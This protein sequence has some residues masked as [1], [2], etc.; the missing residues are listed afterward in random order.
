MVYKELYHGQKIQMFHHFNS[1]SGDYFWKKGTVDVRKTGKYFNPE[2]IGL[3]LRILPHRLDEIREDS[4]N[5][6]CDTILVCPVHPGG[7]VLQ[8]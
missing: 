6:C 3:S 8:S 1:T 7:V 5:C 2:G 4:L